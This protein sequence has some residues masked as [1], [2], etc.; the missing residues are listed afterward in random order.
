MPSVKIL[1]FL[2]EKIYIFDIFMQVH[3][4]QSSASLQMII[5]PNPMKFFFLNIEV[6]FEAINSSRRRRAHSSE[7]R[8]PP[9]HPRLIRFFCRLS[10][11][12]ISSKVSITPSE[13]WKVSF[14]VK[15]DQITIP[16]ST[17][18][19]TNQQI[20]SSMTVYERGNNNRWK[21]PDP[22]LNYEEHRCWYQQVIE[23]SGIWSVILPRAYK[24]GVWVKKGER[25]GWYFNNLQKVY[26]VQNGVFKIHFKKL[27]MTIYIKLSRNKVF[28]FILSQSYNQ[29]SFLSSSFR[30]ASHKSLPFSSRIVCLSF[31]TSR[32]AFFLL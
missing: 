15:R 7:R 30:F 3:S 14:V 27:K 11:V 20:H 19:W 26:F 23:A 29:M 8:P 25:L 1:N 9:C 22:Q 4:S 16:N 32:A 28:L 18:N 5:F 12:L 17:F 10:S 13:S 31:F 6:K 24:K 2:S 21:K